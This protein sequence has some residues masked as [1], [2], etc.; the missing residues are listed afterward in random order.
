[1]ESALL[2]LAALLAGALVVLGSG[3]AS[4]SPDVVPAHVYGAAPGA[5]TGASLY[6]ERLARM[7]ASFRGGPITTSTGAVVNVLVSDA[8]PEE[9]PEEWAEFIAAL[10]HGSELDRLDSTTIATLDEVQAVCGP[11]ALGCYGQNMMVSHG[12]AAIDSVTAEEVV[13]HEYGHLPPPAAPEPEA[14][15]TPMT[16][17]CCV[18]FLRSSNV[19]VCKPRN[20]RVM[21]TP[22]CGAVSTRYTCS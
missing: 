4:A 20:T 9:T 21:R 5:S 11:R 17:A 22:S 14:P 12:D 10:T 19:T 8:L 7:A 15:P 16:S 3:G 6:S 18:P 13:R 1:M 2:R